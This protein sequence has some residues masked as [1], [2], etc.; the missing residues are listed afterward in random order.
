MN[1]SETTRSEAADAQRYSGELNPKDD[2]IEY[3]SQ[4]ARQHPGAVALW[5]LG[6]GFVLGWKLKPW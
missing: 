5:C 1:T 4:Y 2:L 6:I 3:A